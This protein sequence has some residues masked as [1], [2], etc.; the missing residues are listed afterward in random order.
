MKIRIT[1]GKIEF[2]AKM[3]LDRAPETCRLL[4][5]KM[6]ITGKVIQ[7]RWSGEAAWLQM[8]P[9]GIEAP[10]ENA[11][12]YPGPGQILFYPGGVSEKEILIPYGSACFA[13]KFGL[14]PGNHF[15]TVIEGNQL[16]EIMGE[17]VLWGGAQSVRIEKV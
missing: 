15:A 4:L 2:I 7:A 3:H 13:S 5:E 9:Y 10:Q 6:P 14:L 12:S 8:D 1:I 16:L 11:T 17:K